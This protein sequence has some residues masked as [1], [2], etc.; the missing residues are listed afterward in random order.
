MHM[1]PRSVPPREEMLVS[2]NL[3]LE[4]LRATSDTA[5]SRQPLL[6]G[7]GWDRV[8]LSAHSYGTFVAGWVIREGTA[9]GAHSS[10]LNA[11]IAH[12]VL[13]DPIPILLSNPTV[14]HN[15][16]YRSPST[17]CPH[18][19]GSTPTV[20][21]AASPS[22]RAWYSAPAAW[23]LWYFA[24]RD[25]DVAH[26]LFRS[27]FWAEGGLWR[28]DVDEWVDGGRS[29]AVVLGGKDQI[30]PSEAVRRYLTGEAGSVAHWVRPG[31]TEARAMVG[32]Y[33]SMSQAGPTRVYPRGKLEV[34]FNPALDHAVI[35]DEAGWTV[36]LIDVVRRYIAMNN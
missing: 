32:G 36:P 19:L 27:F 4:S 25:A 7:A 12:L 30:V 31:E 1:T 23:Q 3:I 28:E 16:L 29:V 20:E 21:D 17:V 5:D 15:F 18:R 24:S 11:K 6:T 13:V 14:A 34:L 33:G 9:P 26:T 10:G 22:P 2:L 35:F 8:V